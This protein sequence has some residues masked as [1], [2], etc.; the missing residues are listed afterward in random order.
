MSEKNYFGY[1]VRLR[2]TEGSLECVVFCCSASDI[3]KWAG[4]KR[5]KDTDDGTQRV[6][7][8]PRVKAIKRFLNAN[9]LNAI[10]SSIL[11]SFEPKKTK[12][13]PLKDSEQKALCVFD[14][15]RVL[16][17]HLSFSFDEN[18]KECD[19]VALI[20]DGQHRLMGMTG[21]ED[22]DIMVTV[23]AMIDADI[24]EQAFQFIVINNKAVRVPTDNVKAILA[25]IDE[26]Q[27]SER[28]LSAGVAYGEISPILR[29][30]NDL[31]SS[32]FQNLLDWP[33]NRAGKKLISL[34]AIEH[35]LR[36]IKNEFSS[37]FKDD[38]DSLVEFFF[39]VWMEIKE[40]WGM[41]WND[42]P[43]NKFITKVNICA[44]NE[45]VVH[46]IKIIREFGMVDVYTQKS[47]RASCK[48]II[49]PIPNEFWTCRW[50]IKVQDN[51]NVRNT[52]NS[53]LETIISNC[54][55]QRN[56]SENLKLIEGDYIE[57]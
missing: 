7:R 25:G 15:P 41:F 11:I 5:I 23:V 49:A 14:T 3:S 24:Q 37:V 36:F 17:G 9:Q 31:D 10:P 6:L 48:N 27:L 39:S 34:T 44:L 46:R 4:T 18:A 32:P 13:S 56:W 33:Y 50:R 40:K 19:R 35:C 54:K 55:D 1:K 26:T 43:D 53:D 21:I 42:E 38:D 2:K 57:E 47:I 16:Y 45:L 8:E 52:I 12:F 20:V 51:A 30:I 22:G 28:L 29:E